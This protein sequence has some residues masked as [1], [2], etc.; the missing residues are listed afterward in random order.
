M[1]TK[2]TKAKAESP[3]GGS[4]SAAW[5]KRIVVYWPPDSSRWWCGTHEFDPA[6]V[7]SEPFRIYELKEVKR[8][9]KGPATKKRKRESG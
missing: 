5:P 4:P 3:L 2:K 8:V 1:S 6:H 9:P 7:T